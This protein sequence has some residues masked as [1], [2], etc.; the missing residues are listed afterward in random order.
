MPFG[1]PTTRFPLT[2]NWLDVRYYR[3]GQKYPRSIPP[4][5]LRW[6]KLRGYCGGYGS[7]ERT[8]SRRLTQTCMPVGRFGRI[9]GLCIRRTECAGP[10]VPDQAH[11]P[12]SAIDPDRSCSVTCVVRCGPAGPLDASE[13]WNSRAVRNGRTVN[14]RATPDP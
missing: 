14:H 11:S 3:C 2:S 9:Q 10:I 6:R 13:C 1:V 12:A 4:S 7:A 5:Y 8:A